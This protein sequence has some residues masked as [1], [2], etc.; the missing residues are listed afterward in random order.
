MS[1]RNIEMLGVYLEWLDK[2]TPQ[3]YEILWEIHIDMW[4]NLPGFAAK[5]L[6]ERWVLTFKEYYERLDKTGDKDANTRLKSQE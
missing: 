3:D 5:P 4:H 2:L 6:A 1:G